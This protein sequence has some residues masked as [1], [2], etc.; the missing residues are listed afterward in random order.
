MP[1]NCAVP[2]DGTPFHEHCLFST[3]VK[4]KGFIPRHLR[5]PW[6]GLSLFE[7]NELSEENAKNDGCYGCYK[8]TKASNG[9][10]PRE[11]YCACTYKGQMPNEK[12]GVVFGTFN[13]KRQICLKDLQEMAFMP[14]CGNKY[15]DHL[16]HCAM[17]HFYD[18]DPEKAPKKP[19]KKERILALLDGCIIEVNKNCRTVNVKVEYREW[20]NFGNLPHNCKG[21]VKKVF[22]SSI[23]IKEWPAD[24]RN[25][26]CEEM[27]GLQLDLQTG[28][29]VQWR[30]PAGGYEYAKQTQL[31]WQP[32]DLNKIKRNGMPDGALMY[33]DFVLRPV[34]QSEFLL[35]LFK[36]IYLQWSKEEDT[37]IAPQLAA[38]GLAI[39]YIGARRNTKVQIGKVLLDEDSSEQLMHDNNRQFLQEIQFI[40]SNDVFKL[41]MATKMFL[42]DLF[43]VLDQFNSKINTFYG[44]NF[45]KINFREGI[46]AATKINAFAS[47]EGNDSD[48]IKS[49]D[50]EPRRTK[51]VI[52]NVAHFHAKWGPLIGQ[53]IYKN[54]EKFHF[55]CVPIGSDNDKLDLAI[56]APKDFLNLPLVLKELKGDK[57]LD[58][59]TNSPTTEA[60]LIL[61]PIRIDTFYEFKNVLPSIGIR[62]AFNQSTAD[63]TGMNK[64]VPLFIN[65]FIHKVSFSIANGTDTQ[66]EC[67]DKRFS[68]LPGFEGDESFAFLII[69]NKK[70][71]L[72]EGSHRISHRYVKCNHNSTG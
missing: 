47:T 15:F 35:D 46:D 70:N 41:K 19:P 3:V 20:K 63:F 60:K 71:I 10:A 62:N 40:S 24:D 57:L 55:I 11:E 32:T 50:I 21:E 68:G 44:S 26:P 66:F 16:K 34:G 59:V 51:I 65:K 1:R 4:Q 5:P 67:G 49:E 22:E 56:V 2:I 12:F 27:R 64:S 33:P 61:P 9:M 42:S 31:N 45:E 39:A 58:L 13:R 17:V 72:F 37:V 14:T 53:F 6:L 28:G 52:V 43:D 30:D 48:V 29:A 23:E 54:E 8:G 38:V 36:Y 7:D 18:N 69:H 25:G